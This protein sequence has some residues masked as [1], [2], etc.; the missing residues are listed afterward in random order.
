MRTDSINNFSNLIGFDNFL[1]AATKIAQNAS[2]NYPP[3][4]IIKIS[5]DSYRIVIAVAG[6]S[7]N[8]ITITHQN[9]L[10]LVVGTAK[11]DD[12]TAEFLHRGISARN[13]VRKFI[14]HDYVKPSGA[15][16]ENGLLSIEFDRVVP[17]EKKPKNIII[18]AALT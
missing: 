15:S 11:E 1:V 4:N 7:M 13:F 12:A 18:K 14:L 6:F 16:F 3:Y 2:T 9:E 8:E 17:D 5:D 10:L